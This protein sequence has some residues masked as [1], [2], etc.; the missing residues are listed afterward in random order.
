MPQTVVMLTSYLSSA[1]P[2]SDRRLGKRA[3]RSPWDRMIREALRRRGFD[4]RRS[5]NVPFG[6]DWKDDLAA[7][8]NG[9]VGVALDVGANNGQTARS[10]LDRF[11][12]A[13]V[14]SF[15]PNPI[16]LRTLCALAEREPRLEAIGMA[17]SRQAG[18]RELVL[19]HDT[20]HGTLARAPE[21]EE[22]T[23]VI[24][25][26][27]LE[28]FCAERGIDAITLLKIDTEGHEVPVLEGSERVLAERRIQ[29]IVIECA[30][31]SDSQRHGDFFEIHP[32]LARHGYRL[33]AFYAQGVNGN[34]WDWGDVLYR[35][36][37]GE[38]THLR[39]RLY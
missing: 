6:V 5:S 38:P 18:R 4:V 9:Q 31:D 25:T 29:A 10:L 11:P 8:T 28:D 24:P 1:G 2:R 22:E 14:F 27:A 23:T 17:A 20:E 16:A 26:I 12:M 36:P 30:F 33:V 3:A 35:L 19:T 32:L 39:P 15:E 34:G 7:I 21:A 37:D 13:Q